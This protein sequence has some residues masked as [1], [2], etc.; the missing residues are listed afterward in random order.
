MKKL[1]AQDLNN[2]EI[3]NKPKYVIM[4]QKYVF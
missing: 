4:G 1:K 2:F 3:G